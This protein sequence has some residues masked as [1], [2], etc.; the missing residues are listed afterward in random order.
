MFSHNLD[1]QRRLPEDI[2]SASIHPLH[3][4]NTNI[5]HQAVQQNKANVRQN[6][7]RI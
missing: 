3:Y 1:A 7:R 2:R 5:N 6:I 4:T